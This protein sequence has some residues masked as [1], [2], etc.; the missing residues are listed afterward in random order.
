ME[1]CDFKPSEIDLLGSFPPLC[2]TM[3][4][5]EAEMAAAIL[6]RGCQ[7]HGDRWDA[8]PLR[9][10][11][12]VIGDDLDAKREPFSSMN[13]NPF[14]RPDM[15]ACVAGGFAEWEGESGTPEYGVRFTAAGLYALR[16]WL[17][18]QG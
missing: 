14:C 7:V 8:I 18:R 2:G 11:G 16:R 12:A 5:T 17:R 15:H 3:K 4:K 10:L 1:A 6:V 13:R 9:M